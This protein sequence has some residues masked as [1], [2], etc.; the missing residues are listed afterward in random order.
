MVISALAPIALALLL[1]ALLVRRHVPINA[2][3]HLPAEPAAR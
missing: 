2:P 1:M 3:I